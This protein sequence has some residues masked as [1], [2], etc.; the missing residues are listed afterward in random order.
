M[1]MLPNTRDLHWRNAA[2]KSIVSFAKLKKKIRAKPES[3]ILITHGREKH[4]EEKNQT[5]RKCFE[6]VRKLKLRLSPKN[7]IVIS[8][9]LRKGKP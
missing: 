6:I 7:V 1:I 2:V 3:K 8:E 9:E 4:P 5:F